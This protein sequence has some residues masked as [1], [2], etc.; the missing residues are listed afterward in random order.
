MKK[1]KIFLYS[2]FAVILLASSMGAWWAYAANSQNGSVSISGLGTLTA[3]ATV[4]ITVNSSNGGSKPLTL[5]I[6]PPAVTPVYS[7]TVTNL[8]FSAVQNGSLPSDKNIVVTN[9]GNQPLT[10]SYSKSA[11]MTWATRSSS[12]VTLN[13]GASAN[14]TVSINTTNLPPG[15]YTGS[16]NFSNAQGAGNKAST[17]TYTVS[18]SGSAPETPT[19]LSAT[20]S[21][22]D[23]NWLNISWNVS[24][25]ADSYQLYRDGGSTPVSLAS[26]SC[27]AVSCSG[28]DTGLVLGSNHSYQVRAVN[29]FGPSALS[30]PAT[31]GTVASACGGGT[32][33]VASCDS[34]VWYA[35]PGWNYRKVIMLNASKIPSTQINFPVLI[36]FDGDTDLSARAQADGDDIF[37]TS[38]D[39][40]TKLSHE[41]ES[42][43]G[44]NLVAWVKVPILSSAANTKLYMYYGNGSAG[45]QENTASVWGTDFRGVWHLGNGMS[46]D[47]GDSTSYANN[48]SISNTGAAGGKIGGAASFNGTNSYINTGSGGSLDNL[49]NLT[50][51][52]WVYATGWGEG[53]YGRVL[54]KGDTVSYKSLFLADGAPTN[55]IKSMIRS[56]GTVYYSDGGVGS[57]SL[58]GWKHLTMVYNNTAFPRVMRLYIDGNEA[59]GTQYALAGTLDNDS[60]ANLYIGNQHDLTRTFSGYIDEV[61]VSGVARSADWIKTEYNNQSNPSVFHGVSVQCNASA[62][63]VDISADSTDIPNDTS[64]MLHW[65]YSN[66]SDCTITS[67]PNPTVYPN[68]SGSASTGNLT[69]FRNY[70]IS[71]NPGPATDSVLVNVAAAPAQGSLTV[72]KSGQG[73]VVSSPAGI[74]CGPTCQTQ[75]ADYDDGT[76][77]RLDVEPAAGRMF[78]GWG[79][80]CSGVDRENDDNGDGK[81]D[82]TVTVVGDDTVSVIINFAV[83]PNYK[84]F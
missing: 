8:S 47:A 48:G 43:S 2:I 41:I 4:T 19:G 37:F 50:Y 55:S 61:R 27:N 77:V 9:T 42:Y 62:A 38:S 56:S 59:V 83:D 75:S 11:S 28:S 10:I 51:S 82:C 7:Y 6:N 20:A 1:R 32:P 49:S 35:T 30:I 46:L 58:N 22:C 52:A 44:G 80:E 73:T 79:G 70:T 57:M 17:I 15:P 78:T 29:T 66:A 18:S 3:P 13:P 23:N 63:T 39:G 12:S 54:T 60:A 67:Q 25:G 84:E 64:T 21:S 31:W 16:V 76:D 65:T 26:Y 5:I 81:P 68:G 53:N 45:S 71:C 14:V 40:V 33:P 34:T 36:K 24:D 74:N 72:T 69:T